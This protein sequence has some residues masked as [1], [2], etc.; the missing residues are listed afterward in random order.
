MVPPPDFGVATIGSMYPLHACEPPLKQVGAP[1]GVRSS[2]TPSQSSSLPLHSS[3]TARL[4]VALTLQPEVVSE[5]QTMVPLFWQMPTPA[6]HACPSD[7][8]PSRSTVPLQLLSFASHFVSE[9]V[10][11]PFPSRSTD[12][13]PA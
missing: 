5:V 12:G 6:E 1:I 9:R 10:R 13:T 2:I 11:K 4:G 7:G 3:S 8:N